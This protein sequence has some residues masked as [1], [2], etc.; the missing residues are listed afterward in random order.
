MNATVSTQ[1]TTNTEPS[2]CSTPRRIIASTVWTCHDCVKNKKLLS[3][4]NEGAICKNCAINC[5]QNLGHTIAPLYNGCVMNLFCDCN[6]S[7]NEIEAMLTTLPLQ[8]FV[9]D[10]KNPHFE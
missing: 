4:E 1:L 2:C 8:G 6:M 9:S 3:A 5:H 7:G 10:C